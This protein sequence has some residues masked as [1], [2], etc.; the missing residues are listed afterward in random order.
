MAAGI[1][2]RYGGL[3]QIDGFGPNGETIMDYSIYDA[4][5]S[6]FDEVIFILQDNMVEDFYKKF[7][8]AFGGQLKVSHVVQ[9]TDIEYNGSLILRKKP[10]GTAHAILSA[11]NVI[12]TPFV[13]I[14][15]DDFYG[16]KAFKQ[17]A[18]FLSE[19]NSED[20]FALV[21]YRLG[22][23]LTA[24]G[25]VARGICESDGSNYLVSIKEK[26]RIFKDGDRIYNLENDVK[27]YLTTE[28]L[29]SM[30]CWAFTP[31]IFNHIQNSFNDF[32]ARNRQ[33]ENAEL[34]IPNVLNGLLDTGAIRIKVIES[35]DPWFGVTYRGDKE[36]ATSKIDQL[37]KE[38][39][40]P[41][42]L[43]D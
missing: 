11:R 2:S 42:S 23:T 22:N 31:S 36:K 5:K 14:N 43:W 16:P 21:G 32:I 10:W 24:S 20:Q 26:T 29:V 28:T 8:H 41:A 1:G 15:A 38:G 33:S 6:G 35:I 40:Y 30:N 27:E 9:R 37:I 25:H 12:D 4:I 3:K 34:F 7:D 18:N 19:V 39:I 13:V 17:M